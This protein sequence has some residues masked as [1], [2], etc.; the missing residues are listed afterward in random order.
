[1]DTATKQTTKRA[2]PQTVKLTAK[3][4]PALKPQMVRRDVFDSDVRGLSL[5]IATSGVRSWCLHYRVGKQKKRW[6][7]G[8]ADERRGGLSLASARSK[9]R[10]ALTALHDHGI[11]PAETKRANRTASTFGELVDAF[12]KDRAK[13]KS[14]GQYER[15]LRKVFLP[16]W[17]H[18]AAKEITRRDVAEIITEIA[19]SAPIGANR[20]LAYVSAVFTFG[21][22]R[23]WIDTNPCWKIERKNEGDGRSRVLTDDEIRELFDAHLAADP[24]Q[25]Y[26]RFEGAAHS[27]GTLAKRINRFANG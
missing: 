18:R 23:F 1:M 11:D 10:S 27:I 26:C 5:R 7:I 21:V 15:V 9:A 16:V 22:R 20:A 8:P 3:A 6:T 17:K 14:I 24:A 19:T 2:A 4:V 25:V 12:L 13:R